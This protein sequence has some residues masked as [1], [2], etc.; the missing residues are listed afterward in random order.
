MAQLGYGQRPRP[1]PHT[2]HI[3]KCTGVPELSRE[4]AQPESSTQ[5]DQPGKGENCK[6][7]S[8]VASQSLSPG[9]LRRQTPV[10]VQTMAGN[11][12]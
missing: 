4:W 12:Q 8:E 9:V 1:H 10:R 11:Y 6:L 5:G 2:V 7:S 3:R